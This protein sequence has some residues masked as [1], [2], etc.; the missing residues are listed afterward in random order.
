MLYVSRSNYAF[1]VQLRGRGVGCVIRNMFVGCILYADD[2]ILLCPSVKGLQ[3]MLNV[4]VD[5]ANS[6]SL[7]FNTSKSMCL[8][9]GKLAKLVTLQPM[10]LGTGQVDWVDSIK[11]LSLI[12]I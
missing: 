10:L 4:C 9:I 7:V 3:S 8:A 2:M 1:I 12:H 11:Y 5:V 6:L